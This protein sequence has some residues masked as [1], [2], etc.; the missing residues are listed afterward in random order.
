MSD[1]KFPKVYSIYEPP[2][3]YEEVNSGEQ[4]TEQA[5]YIPAQV[6]IEEMIYAGERLAAARKERF[7]FPSDSEVPDDFVDPTRSPGFDLA[8]ASALG[9]AAE[10]RM[11]AS[12]AQAK[13]AAEEAA[14]AKAASEQAKE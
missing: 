14:A 1:V 8:D 4:V 10:L 2:P 9:T 12:A 7:D 5:G 11:K 13:K 6:Q 3:T